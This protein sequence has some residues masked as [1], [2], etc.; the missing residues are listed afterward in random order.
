MTTIYAILTL[1]DDTILTST[2]KSTEVSESLSHIPGRQ[3][4]GCVASRLYAQ[5]DTTKRWDIFHGGAVRF[6][7]AV[8][9]FVSSTNV[10]RGFVCPLSFHQKKGTKIENGRLTN[11]IYN[12]LEEFDNQQFTQ[13]RGQYITAQG[14]QILVH[15]RSS[16]RVSLEKGRAKEGFLF[17]YHAVSKGTQFL[18][19]I[20]V[21]NDIYTNDIMTALG[22]EIRIGR[23][24]TAEYGRAQVQI[25][26]QQIVSNTLVEYQEG[27]SKE[28]S[29]YCASD[30]ALTNA[31]GM[32]SISVKD[33]ASQVGATECLLS[34]TFLRTRVY[35][36]FHG[37]RCRPD[38]ERQVILAGSVITM[39]FSE[40]QD[41]A[42]LRDKFKNGIGEHCHEGLGEIWI[43]PVFLQNSQ[44]FSHNTQ[45]V[46]EH[47]KEKK[48]LVHTDAKSENILPEFTWLKDQYALAYLELDVL[49][50]AQKWK[51]EL[52]Q[53]FDK[54]NLKRITS[55]Q[56]GQ[57]RAY[58]KSFP[59]RTALLEYLV[60]GKNNTSAERKGYLYSGQRKLRD[61]WGYRKNESEISIANAFC[62]LME[63]EKLPLHK[64]LFTFAKLMQAQKEK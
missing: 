58:A 52:E 7:D 44:P 56:W 20:D 33:F 60:K 55:S 5:A 3:I 43:D 12:L 31:F 13:L 16:M 19:R 49:Q 51:E 21:E 26:T 15:K 35:S 14:Y 54:K 41:R 18:A 28:I 8:P 42:I 32:P 47:S 37:F 39:I 24:K 11:N 1:K 30:I 38:S 57:I 46:Y 61:Q 25:V 63:E 34:K 23:S 48:E 10:T 17:G 62:K 40:P 29:F 64:V 6:F 45:N 50:Q 59:D 2:N 36:P 27:S 9:C 53:I 22:T 4:L